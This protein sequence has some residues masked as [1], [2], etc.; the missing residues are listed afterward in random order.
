MKPSMRF[1]DD[2]MLANTVGQH[3]QPFVDAEKPCGSL[4]SPYH[5]ADQI[6]KKKEE[7]SCLLS[8]ISEIGFSTKLDE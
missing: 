2:R 3:T 5:G 1:V 8:G 7:H 6:V 4:S